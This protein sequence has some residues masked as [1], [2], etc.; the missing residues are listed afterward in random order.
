MRVT[1]SPARQQV[2]YF[3]APAW[4]PLVGSLTLDF[5]EAVCLSL[6]TGVSNH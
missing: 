5:S 4:L 3:V 2:V 1:V 6:Q